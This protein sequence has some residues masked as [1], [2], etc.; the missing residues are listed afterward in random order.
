[1]A[2]VVA[3]AFVVVV[4]S[5]SYRPTTNL[6]PTTGVNV[7]FVHK[8]ITNTVSTIVD[9]RYR[10][11]YT[12]NRLDRLIETTC[13]ERTSPAS[14]REYK[15]DQRAADIVDSVHARN[16]C[17]SVDILGALY[18]VNRWYTLITVYVS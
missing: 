7:V 4:A 10:R 13:N 3:V 9:G 1:V 16:L 18:D 12:K 17:S 2:A 11:Y 5:V 15:Q 6:P 14:S 8:K